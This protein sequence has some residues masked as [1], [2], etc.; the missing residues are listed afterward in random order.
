MCSQ[1]T[2][3]GIFVDG[4]FAEYN[5]AP[6]RAL[7]RIPETLSS[8]WAVFVEPLSCV[9]NAVNKLKPLAGES[10]VILGAGPMGLLFTQVLAAAGVKPIIVSEVSGFRRK[11]A[12]EG[13]AHAVVDP[14]TED[15]KKGVHEL[16]GIGADIAVDAVGT[17]LKD[18]L[19]LV[20]TGG[21]V[22]LF[23]QNENARADIQQYYITRHEKQVLGSFIA[24]FTFPQAVK[25]L[26]S[27]L[28]HVDKLITHR[29]KLEEFGES[30][31]LLKKGEAIKVIMTP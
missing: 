12:E 10:A 19:E 7:H 31:E 25:L 13:G 27:G 22:M 3:L 1:M 2:T 9:L 8:E 26:D 11:Y 18:A 5:I 23:G 15:L 6:E 30:L 4:G 21:R 17:L 24:G 16:T 29:I 14:Q 20:R 28:L